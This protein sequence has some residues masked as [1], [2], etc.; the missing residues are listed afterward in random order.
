[1]FWQT[2]FV[3]KL[4]NCKLLTNTLMIKCSNGPKILRGKGG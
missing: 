3:C 2:E 4:V 1:M